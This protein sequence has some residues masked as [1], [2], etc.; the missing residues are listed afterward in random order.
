MKRRAG[1]QTTV[2]SVLPFPAPAEFLVFV[3]DEVEESGLLEH[4]FFLVEGTVGIGAGGFDFAGVSDGAGVV[5]D[6]VVGKG[7][8]V[9]LVQTES[10]DWGEVRGSP[11]AGAGAREEEG[12]SFPHPL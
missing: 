9:A 8:G 10:A 3:G 7:A 4:R 2:G 11:G 5:T 6:V 12:M 1:H